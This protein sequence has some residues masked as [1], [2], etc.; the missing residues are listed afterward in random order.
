M[1]WEEFIEWDRKYYLHH[2]YALQE[3]LP[4]TVERVEGSWIVDHNGNKFLD[5]MGGWFNINVGQ[6]RPEIADEIKKALDRYGWVPETYVTP[7]KS[8]AAK[9]I[10]ED[11]LGHDGWAGRV[12]FVNSGSEANEEAIIIA[13]LY[14]NRRNILSRMGYNGWTLGAGSCTGHRANRSTLASP[15]TSESRSV[16]GLPLEG[17]YFAPEPYCYRC[18][19][20]HEYPDCKE[21]GRLA[22]VQYT[23]HLI[24]MIGPETFAA[25]LMEVHVGGPSY[26]PP[27]EYIPQIR[28]M[29]DEYGILWIDD[30]VICG[31]GRLGRWFGY[32]L[33]E[34]VKPDIMTLAKGITSSQL[35][36]GAVVVSKKI[37]EFFDQYRW[38]HYVTFGAHPVCM[39]AVVANIKVMMKEKL[40]ER[41]ER[42]GRYLGEKLK[43]L[44]ERHK[45]VG[46]VNGAGLFWIIE[47]VK[48]KETKE[49]FVKEDRV[50]T[51][52]GDLSNYPNLIVT[53]RALE[54]GVIAG[55]FVPNT[56]RIGPALTITEDEIDKGVDALDYALS[57]VDKM[58][59]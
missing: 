27:P 51:F 33:Y 57:E 28:K 26:I 30:E 14:T 9:L 47:L 35:P 49:P 17:F 21:N 37:A 46:L 23:K 24:Q 18:P 53:K 6:C 38:L 8:E 34:G 50:A 1:S 43:A 48:N 40:P 4:F 52:A 15:T 3:W 20:G 45:S 12:R 59:E 55:G 22:C 29:L 54:K 39:A 44:E 25:M 19:L 56:L 2:R 16:P 11:L 42:M 41:S 36:V 31:F 32:Q 58:T 7:Y 5:F 13:R 10:V